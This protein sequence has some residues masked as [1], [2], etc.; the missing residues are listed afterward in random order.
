L[1]F[2]V[3]MPALVAGIH[4]GATADRSRPDRSR[5]RATLLLP[6]DVDRRDKPGDDGNF[7][8]GSRAPALGN[9]DGD[10]VIRC[11]KNTATS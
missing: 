11:G 7:D 2:I 9:D 4:V 8:A 1:P 3:V 10:A 5:C 6:D